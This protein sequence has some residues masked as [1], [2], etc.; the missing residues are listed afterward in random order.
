MIGTRGSVGGRAVA[1][2]ALAALLL[3][4][5]SDDDGGDPAS[6]TTAPPTSEA[7]GFEDQVE[8]AAQTMLD[9][10]GVNGATAAYVSI[11]DPENGDVT[12]VLGTLASDGADPASAE[13]NIPIGSITKTLTATVILQMIDDGDLSF[14]DTVADLL[15]DLATEHP[16]IADIT[17]EQLLSMTSGISDYANVP[18]A[19]VADLVDDPTKV[20]EPEELI[21]AGVGVGVDHERT[22]GYSTTNYIILQ[23]VAE[24]IAGQ[25]LEEL[26]TSEVTAPLGLDRM[27]L[28]PPD[29][30]T[31]PD[32]H[33]RGY[34]AGG[35]VDEVADD[36]A[37][38]EDP[39]DATDWNTS[40]TQGGGGAYATIGDLLGWAEST[41]GSTLLSDEL[42]AQRLETAPLREGFQ[43]G[44]GILELGTS[45]YG[46]AGEALGWEALAVTDPDTG[47][48]VAVAMN[49]CGG[50]I[51]Y[52]AEFLDTIYPDGAITGPAAE[53][54][55]EDATEEIPNETIF[56]GGDTVLQA[57]WTA[58]TWDGT[59]LTVSAETDGAT[60][61]VTP[62]DGG[63]V[64]ITVTG[65]DEW[66]ATGTP[67]EVDGVIEVE[68]TGTGP[69]GDEAEITLVVYDCA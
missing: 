5:C 15:P 24:S 41:V 58:C 17:V 19:V 49:G 43:Y 34:I 8:A 53:S 50:Q 10:G 38:V 52:F 16:D 14:D 30:T 42:A 46:H 28:P 13:D 68:G 69:D 56:I 61:E 31:L 63:D 23:L 29:D 59:A 54:D 26:I 66:T 35:C 20:W 62:A 21:A 37:T 65:A 64:G 4:A 7:G 48:S 22:P 39:T 9:D 32:P 44:L 45:W 1:G 51:Q 57:G 55:D 47:V 60:I 12:V 33:P 3:T 36:G 11:S 6:S 18:D 67:T 2:V 40:F 27:V 25:P